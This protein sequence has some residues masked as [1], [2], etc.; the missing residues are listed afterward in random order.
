MAVVVLVVSRLLGP[1]GYAHL[2][3][4]L[5]VAV[6]VGATV[7]LVAARIAGIDELTALLQL[8]RRS[9]SSTSPS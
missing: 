4:R 7:Y 6:G 5:G 1:G 8:R 2:A 3:L 9:P